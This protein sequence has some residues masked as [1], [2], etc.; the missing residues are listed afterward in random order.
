MLFRST[1]AIATSID[2]LAVGIS[3]S[4]LQ[5]EILLP[6]LMIG[7]ITFL[8]SY[9]GV[10]LGKMIGC[11]TKLKKYIDIFGGVILVGIGLKILLEHI[12]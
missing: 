5:I 4:A 3:F 1:L 6:A 9:F 11:N 8:L 7:V 10:Y 2:A 12:L